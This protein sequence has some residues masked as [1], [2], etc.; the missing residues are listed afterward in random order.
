M[1]PERSMGCVSSRGGKRSFGERRLPVSRSPSFFFLMI[2][3]PPRSTLFPYT[4]LFRS[5]PPKGATRK[6]EGVGRKEPPPP[7]AGR[8][9]GKRGGIRR[10]DAQDAARSQEL[11]TAT[12]AR[13]RV[14]EVLHHV[15]HHDG[16]I[17]RLGVVL[18]ERLL[19]DAEAELATCIGGGARRRFEPLDVVSAPAGLVQQQARAAADI[20]QPPCGG[21][22]PEHVEQASGGPPPTPLLEQ[23]CLVVHLP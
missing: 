1:E 5:Q 10:D 12:D 17:P 2:R 6:Q 20:E 9:S 18:V 4:T 13:D 23:V 22:P 15:S 7:R 11:A 3:R 8:A 21:A 19:V 16:V 14:V